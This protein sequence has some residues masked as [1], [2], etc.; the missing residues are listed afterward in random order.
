MIVPRIHNDGSLSVRDVAIGDQ[1]IVTD[2]SL[3]FGDLYGR[4]AVLKEIRDDEDGYNYRVAITAT[5]GL[6]TQNGVHET[7]VADISTSDPADGK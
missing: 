1:V 4:A 7:W 3:N 2:S 6:V 5:T